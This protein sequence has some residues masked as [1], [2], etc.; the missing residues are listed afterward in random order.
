[1]A[2]A[3]A[4]VGEPKVLLADEPTGNLDSRNAQTV[5]DL[6]RAL[7]ENGGTIVMVT[8]DPRSA[9]QAQRQI[10]LFDG[11]VVDDRRAHAATA[12]AWGR[13]A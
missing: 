10:L 8:H 3:Q 6:L 2:I 11:K 5:L 7:H 9:E 4:L 13:T 1:M 12:P